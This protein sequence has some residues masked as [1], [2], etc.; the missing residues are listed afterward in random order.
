MSRVEADKERG[1]EE[2]LAL[3][4]RLTSLFASGVDSDAT[5]QQVVNLFVP[6]FAAWCAIDLFDGAGALR[7]VASAAHDFPDGHNAIDATRLSDKSESEV[8]EVDVVLDSERAVIVQVDSMARLLWPPHNAEV[9]AA[10]ESRLPISMVFAPLSA[11]GARLGVLRLAT[12]NGERTFVPD[13]ARLVEDVAQRAA[14]AIHTAQLVEALQREVGLRRATAEALELSETR[15]RNLFRASPFPLWVYDSDTLRFLAV[16]DAAIAQYGFSADEFLART[17]R[18]IRLPEDMPILDHALATSRQGP[19]SSG[20]FR[21]RRKDGSLFIVDVRSDAIVFDGRSARLTTAHDVTDR[22]RAYEDLRVAEERH[23]LVSHATK[24]AIWEWNVASDAVVW[25]PAFCELFQYEPEQVNPTHSWYDSRIHPDDRE[26][27]V[28]ELAYAFTERHEMCSR[29]F[30]FQRGDGVFANVDDRAVIAYNGHAV[31]RVVGSLADI[32]VQQQLSEQLA[33]AQ[34]MEAIGRLAGGVA[35]DFNNLLTAIRGFASFAMEAQLPGASARDD[36]DQILF[37][38]DRAAAL[39]RQLLAF[40]RRQGLQPQLV[41]VNEVIRTLQ[42]MLTRVLGEDI[43]L[44]TFLDHDTDLVLVD[45]GQFEQMIMNLV[46][47]ARDA[48]PQGGLLTI[49]TSNVLLDAAY[50][51]AHVGATAGAHVSVAITDN[52]IG[53]DTKTMS[54]IFEPFFSTKERDKG[55]GLG[56]ATTYGFIKESG[57]HI[58]VYSEPGKGSTFKVYLPRANDD[59]RLLPLPVPDVTRALNGTETILVVEDDERVRRVSTLALQRHGYRVLEARSGES[60]LALFKEHVDEIAMVVTDVV[61]PRMSGP[62]LMQALRQLR[63]DIPSLFVSGYTEN[64]NLQRGN[65]DVGMELLEKPF[66]P[67]TLVRRVR[68]I[69][70]RGARMGAPTGVPR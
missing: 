68:A 46:V 8:S 37:A 16:N 12:A 19:R 1:H 7:R 62:Q 25:N 60:A 48:I 23:R 29:R 5:L 47:N 50:E 70:D 45:P 26:A 64:A 49:E 21:H 11:H 24:E 41:N 43:D 67:E 52:G 31:E 18:D 3:L 32:T 61:L 57:G 56:L 42:L 10:I 38:A 65:T 59:A 30:R 15:Y 9:A 22:V 58:W 17:I 14:F 2:R 63:V 44:Q 51:E 55:T 20:T 34:R 40:S 28:A 4:S 27:A 33:I 66:A 69:L 13:D 36:I 53:M 35:H 54:R 6:G 39:T